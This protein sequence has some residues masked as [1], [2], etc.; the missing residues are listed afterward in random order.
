MWHFPSSKGRVWIYSNV[1]VGLLG[2]S[3]EALNGQNFNTL[4]C[5]H[6]LTPLGMEPIGI[7]VPARLNNEYAQ[8]YQSNGAPAKRVNLAAREAAGSM[9]ASANDMFHFLKALLVCL[10]RQN[11]FYHPFV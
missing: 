8:G 4:Y 3:L 1:G 6:I 5:Q 9:K 7:D 11:L 10:E 2:D